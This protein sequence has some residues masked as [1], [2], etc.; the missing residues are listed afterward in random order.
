LI[1]ET[2][3]RSL[4]IPG[5][6]FT[7]RFLDRLQPLG[8]LALRIVLGAIMIGHGYP[9]IFG[10]LS[11]HL[12][13]VQRIG[14]PAWVGYLSAGTEFFG[15]MLMI[16]GLLTR[17]IG[18]AM[19]FEMTVAILKMHLK[20]GMIGQGGYEFPLALGTM[21]FAL[22]FFG[23]GPISLDAVIKRGGGGGDKKAR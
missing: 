4:F 5:R 20:N 6:K 9:K 8:L 7:L 10:G 3:P 11:H 16:A 13:T 12:E 15:G 22:I 2:T 14:F 21:A 18:F 1:E 23:A 19:C 17:F